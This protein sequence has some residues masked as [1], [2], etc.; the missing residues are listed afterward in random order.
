MCGFAG[1]LSQDLPIDRSMLQAAGKAIQH[2]GPDHQGV[3]INPAGSA[4]F[5][6]QRLSIQ[7][8]DP[9]ANQPF[10]SADKRYLIVYNGEVYNYPELRQKL[11]ASNVALRTNCDTEAILERYIQIG[12]ACLEELNGMFAFAIWDSYDKSLFIARDRLGIKPLYYTVEKNCFAFTSDLKAF[13]H[14]PQVSKVLNVDAI[15]QY[16]YF[17]YVPQPETIYQKVHKLLPGHH[18]TVKFDFQ[19]EV[20]SYWSLQEQSKTARA[21]KDSTEHFR[22]LLKE[23]VQKRLLSDVEVGAFSSGGLDS[24]S[25]VSLLGTNQLKTFTIG[26]EHQSN[27]LD[28]QRSKELSQLKDVPQIINIIGENSLQEFADFFSLMDE[29]LSEA[30]IVP[31]LF[32]FKI[33]REHGVKVVLSGDGAD[34]LLGG[35]GYFGQIANYERW[36]G[37]PKALWQIG[38]K[39]TTLALGGLPANGNL[40]KF[41]DLR[42]RKTLQILSQRDLAQCH[43]LI[44][45]QNNLADIQKIARTPIRK[46]R[47][48][49]MAELYQGNAFSSEKVLEVEM[50]S[51]LVNKHLAKVDKASMAHS[52]EARVP[53]LDHELV[54]FA[55]SLK[56]GDRNGKKILKKAMQGI[57]P[58]N[59]IQDKK[60]GFNLP[61]KPWSQ[62]YLSDE[63][64]GYIDLAALE[65]IGLFEQKGIQHLMRENKQGI[66]DHSRTLWSLFVLSGWLKHN[67]YELP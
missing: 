49:H 5:V 62:K 65:Q 34:E 58:D 17:G 44:L 30:S 47:D 54:A 15:W 39:L 67:H 25:I 24:S 1:I 23:S 45:S 9:R 61:L 63:G 46:I 57:V 56:M 4:G 8:L 26:F 2:R 13:Q 18:L 37:T 31:L 6:H 51:A 66:I 19:P 35:Y 40:G 52:V 3:F 12:A 20:K 41:R 29:P 32:N 21:T 14:F 22:E 42:L 36:Q 50:Q 38:M 10:F 48:A 7:D 53:F 11:E 33:A 55:T 16:L 28:L 60:R 27:T 64:S 59:I 43:E